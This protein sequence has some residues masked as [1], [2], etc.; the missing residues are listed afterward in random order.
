M[1]LYQTLTQPLVLLKIMPI[2]G[3]WQERRVYPC[4]LLGGLNL[5]AHLVDVTSALGDVAIEIRDG[6]VVCVC[7][8]ERESWVYL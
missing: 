1:G 3:V 8:R 4:S 2:G 6:V 7:E 5:L